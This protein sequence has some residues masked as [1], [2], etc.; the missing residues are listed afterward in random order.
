MEESNTPK[1]DLFD[2]FKS[3]SKK[4]MLLWTVFSYIGYYCL[5][6]VAPVITIAV[7]YNM[8]T[9]KA[10][11]SESN[12][13]IAGWGLVLLMIALIVSMKVLKTSAEKVDDVGKAG[14]IF[15][16]T[17]KTISNIILPLGGMLML[18]FLTNNFNLAKDTLM[19]MAIFYIIAGIIDGTLLSV[20]D[21]EN[22][23]RRKAKLAN[24]VDARR[25]NV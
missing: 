15:K 25:S 11:T 19:I 12:V 3:L 24:E 7:K 1:K 21:R 8:F 5:A 2:Y 13:N 16:Y 9:P 14:A 6:I 22:N 20:I 4:A 23:I 17:I 18:Y 10:D